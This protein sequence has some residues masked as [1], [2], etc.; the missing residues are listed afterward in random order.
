MNRLMDG[1]TDG[2]TDRQT[3]GGQELAARIGDAANVVDIRKLGFV[4]EI[5]RADDGE[6]IAA[7]VLD[8]VA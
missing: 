3:N 2:Q 1:R 8:S 5:R 4:K 7:S 6:T